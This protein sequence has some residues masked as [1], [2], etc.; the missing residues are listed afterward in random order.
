[1]L[2]AHDRRLVDVVAIDVDDVGRMLNDLLGEVGVRAFVDDLPLV[3][4][5]VEDLQGPDTPRNTESFSSN[6]LHSNSCYTRRSALR[7]LIQ[8][9]RV[10][11]HDSDKVKQG[12]VLMMI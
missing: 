11:Q 12:L 8:F 7:G 10:Y 3:G 5:G 2:V 1:M 6:K 9:T 4:A